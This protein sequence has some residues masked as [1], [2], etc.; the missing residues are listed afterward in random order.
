M[1]TYLVGGAVRDKLLGFPVKERDYVVVGATPTEMIK[2]GFKSVGKDFPV[3]LEPKTKEEYAL[4]RTERKVGRGY[5]GF[6]FNTSPD[7]TL[8]EDLMRRDLTINAMAEDTEGNLI[9]YYSGKEDLENRILRHVSPAFAEDPV[10]ILRV[11]RFAARYAQFG[12]TVAPETIQ[13]MQQMVDNGEVDALVPERVWKE[14]ERALGEKNPEVFFQVLADC[15]ALSTLFPEIANMSGLKKAVAQSED[16]I[17][18]FAVLVSD[19]SKSSIEQMCERYRIPTSYRE[20][21]LNLL[22]V[23]KHPIGNDEASIL[24]LLT[25]LDAF[26]REERFLKTLEGAKI[27][28]IDV[29]LLRQSF[30]AAKAISAGPFLKEGFSGK[31]LG[32]RIN[33]E[34]L[35]VIDQVI[36]QWNQTK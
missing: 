33:V 12:F 22:E 34:R 16:T 35:K 1:K 5:T 14:L 25:K 36:Q 15:E 6:E 21:A 30:D 31:E 18:R 9:D 20:L 7:V 32:E 23:T 17:I 3:F 24:Q 10:R 11:A 2:L 4:A 27:V 29:Q 8:K 28:N 13:L 26:R 19:L